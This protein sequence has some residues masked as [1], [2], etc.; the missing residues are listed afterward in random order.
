MMTNKV[1]NV[2]EYDH[3]YRTVSKS[4]VRKA[5]QE[6]MKEFLSHL[7]TTDIPRTAESF[8]RI[9]RHFHRFV[10]QEMYPGFFRKAASIDSN[11]AILKRRIVRRIQRTN[12]RIKTAALSVDLKDMESAKRMLK[13]LMIMPSED[14]LSARV[15]LSLDLLAHCVPKGEG[16]MFPQSIIKDYNEIFRATSMWI[17]PEEDINIEEMMPNITIEDKNRRR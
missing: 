4:N 8:L 1:P 17:V 15:R 14:S 7:P 13:K 6:L 11:D 16:G 12:L 5:V 9:Y 3:Y 10:S 2:F